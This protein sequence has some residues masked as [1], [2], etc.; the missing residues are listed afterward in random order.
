[1]GR[2]CK[3]ASE[4]AFL[5]K[6]HPVEAKVEELKFELDEERAIAQATQ[7]NLEEQLQLTR[8]LEIEIN[9]LKQLT[10]EVKLQNHEIKKN[11]IVVPRKRETAKRS[12][13]LGCFGSNTSI[14]HA[15]GRNDRI[16][17]ISICWRC[18]Q[19]RLLSSRKLKS[20]PSDGVSFLGGLSCVVIEYL[21]GR[22]QTSN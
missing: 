2:C 14:G 20:F 9:R 16:R 18:C 6:S 15:I 12:Y 22:S 17:S 8:R 1:M 21:S 7:E 3:I 10:S 19:N 13:W 11:G 4:N 5:E